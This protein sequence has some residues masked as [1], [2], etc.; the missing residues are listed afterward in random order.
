MQNVIAFALANDIAF[1]YEDGTLVASTAGVE[2][3]V[4]EHP[5]TEGVEKVLVTRGD[6]TEVLGPE[7]AITALAEVARRTV[8]EVSA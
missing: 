5:D 2:V 4:W 7:H 3:A 6:V 8:T 1:S